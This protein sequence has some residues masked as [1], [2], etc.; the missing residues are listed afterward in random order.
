MPHHQVGVEDQFRVEAAEA[1]LPGREVLVVPSAHVLHLHPR[2]PG[3]GERAI[4]ARFPQLAQHGRHLVPGL[5]RAL[6]IELRLAEGVLVV[7]KD[8]RRDV[9]RQ[10]KQLATS[11]GEVACNCRQERL[12]IDVLGSLREHL[13]YRPVG[14]ARSHHVGRP[15][16]GHLHEVR[17]IAGALRCKGR[18]HGVFVAALV[19]G[20]DTDLLLRF[21]EA[22]HERLERVAERAAHR[23]PE[24]DFLLRLRERRET[25]EQR[26]RNEPSNHEARIV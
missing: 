7:E 25:G 23:V 12:R 26:N 14:A 6:G 15:D 22:L 19:L 5:R 18:D 24:P 3:R 4:E 16:F 2:G 8:R 11:V 20:D 10:C 9:E 1:V 21:V 13:P 17:C